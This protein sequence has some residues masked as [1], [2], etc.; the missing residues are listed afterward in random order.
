MFLF[1]DMKDFKPEDLSSPPMLSQFSMEEIR[2]MKFT[3][4]YKKVPSHSQAVERFVALTSIAGANA[5]G[6]S[7]YLYFR[8]D[9]LKSYTFV[10]VLWA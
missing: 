2:E 10:F 7:S 8:H 6:N 3:D 4:A 5:I 1:T 9:D